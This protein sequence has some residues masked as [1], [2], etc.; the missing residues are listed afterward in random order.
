MECVNTLNTMPT[1][2]I[3]GLHADK[4]AKG[5]CA[6]QFARLGDQLS[7]AALDHFAHVSPLVLGVAGQRQR[8]GARIGSAGC[9][10]AL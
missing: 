8:L 1:T 4:L 6:V 3:C 10:R 7:G 9:A 5:G 2:G